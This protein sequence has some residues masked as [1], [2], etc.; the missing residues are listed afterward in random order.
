VVGLVFR[1]KGVGAPSIDPR[2]G[3]GLYLLEGERVVESGHILVLLFKM[4]PLSGKRWE[5][6][7]RF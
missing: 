1:K 5:Y 4:G 3:L 6:W 7:R 2:W